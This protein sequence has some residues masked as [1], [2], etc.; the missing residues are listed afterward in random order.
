MKT[1]KGK[2]AQREMT[3]KEW[4]RQTKNCPEKANH[5]DA[6]AN[7]AERQ[8]EMDEDVS[9]DEHFNAKANH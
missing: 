8:R 7:Q 4:L 3:L 2:E 5:L 6:L 1:T 9:I